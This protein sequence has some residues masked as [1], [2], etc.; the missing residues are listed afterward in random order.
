M[1][2]ITGIGT[3]SA[4]GLDVASNYRSLLESRDGIGYT[5]YIDT[6]HKT[7]LPVGEV[8]LSNEEFI[9]WLA[10]DKRD[11]Y[12]RTELL[13][14]K[15]ASEAHTHAGLSEVKDRTRIALISG[16]SVGGMD[17]SERYYKGYE[18]EN[19]RELVA[20]FRKHGCFKHTETVSKTLKVLGISTTIST[21]CSSAANAIIYGA[22]LIDA[23]LADVVIAG[24]VDPLSKFTINGFNSLKIL[25]TQPTRPFDDSRVGLNLAEGAGYVVLESEQSFKQ[26]GVKPL[27][28]LLGYANTCDAYHQT[29]SSPEGKGAVLAMTNALT[30]ANLKPGDVDYVNVH[31]TG[32]QNNDLSEGTALKTVFND[33]VPA[34]SSTKSYTGH[35]LGASGGIEAAY[36]LLAINNGVVYPNLRFKNSIADL[37]ISP[38]QE[39]EY[40]TVNIVLSNSFGFG[41]NN[42]SLVFGK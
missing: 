42:T 32:T 3:V 33:Q 16:T 29:A 22:R 25:D 7:I 8:K 9:D 39:I 4:I 28:R 21:A 24:G 23:G 40:K 13:A 41:G 5:Q 10:L 36:S 12:S 20:K 34:F 1:T 6:Y 26:R 11:I 38:Q 37:G 35:T 17:L 18:L 2:W 27:G 14:L 31:G 15:A 30:M 19:K